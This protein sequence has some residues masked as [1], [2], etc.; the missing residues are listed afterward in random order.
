MEEVNS[1]SGWF[2]GTGI[3]GLETAPAW[4][5]SRRTPATIGGRSAGRAQVK[6]EGTWEIL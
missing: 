1:P 4:S 2:A 5:A 3:A 6:T